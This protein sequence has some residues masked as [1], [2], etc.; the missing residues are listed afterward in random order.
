VPGHID[1]AGDID[2]DGTL[3][4]DAITIGSTA[5]GSIYSVIAGNTSLVTTGALGT[6]SIATGFGN[7]DN[8]SSTIT[9][10]GALAAGATT[11]TG[12]TI[13]GNGYGL[14]V[15]NSAQIATDATP[16]LQYLG[17]ANAD[18][19]AVWG[20]WSNDAVGSQLQFLKS[21]NTS[22]GSQTIVQDDDQLGRITSYA[23]DGNDNTHH[24]TI[25]SFEVDGTPGENDVPGRIVFSTTADGAVSS[26]E[27]MRIN[28]V[29]QVG[30]GTN[31]PG[32][33][34]QVAANDSSQTVI[35]SN[36]HAN[37]EIG[38]L[39]LEGATPNN[40][41]WFWRGDCDGIKFYIFGD[42]DMQ[43]NDNS[44]GGI[45]D[46]KLKQDITDA[47]DY[48]DDFKRV[49]FRKFR[50]KQEVLNY[51]E[52]ARSYFG[53][54]SQEVEPIFP[55]LIQYTEN[56]EQRDVP[57]LDEDGNAIYKTDEDGN[58]IPLTESQ[59]VKTGEITQGFRY[60]ILS[61]IGLKVVQELQARC[62]ALESK[63]TALEAA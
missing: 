34:L 2:V 8:G 54:V 47:R 38:L 62:E 61:Q 40:T 20:R 41:E 4:A 16:E 51:G 31:A 10:T 44:Y 42:G 13:V 29:G 17:T 37:G 11:I 5:I 24:S 6:G 63:V 26:T 60:S 30:I 56:K 32:R 59:S 9:T 25:I 50:F 58:T 49:R 3:E 21:R 19:R 27:R 43:N 23:D 1:L 53:V 46:V 52:D 45:S 35:F 48:W 15:G 39:G 7:I 28:S 55:G 22:I 18:T 14:V 12:D 36:A 33:M 57:V